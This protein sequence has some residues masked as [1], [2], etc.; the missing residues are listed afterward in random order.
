MNKKWSIIIG[1]IILIS[2]FITGVFADSPIKL[3]VNGQEI[4]PDAAPQIINGNTMVPISWVAK[5][6]GADVKWDKQNNAVNITRPYFVSNQAEAE[7]KLYPFQNINGM[8][9]GFILEVKGERKYFA[10]ENVTNPTYAPELLFADIN[11]DSEKEL[12]ILLTT[13]TGTGVHKEDIHVINPGMLT[14]IAVESPADIV[15]QNINTKMQSD[16]DNMVIQIITGGKETTIIKEKEYSCSWFNNVAF[17]S[18]CHYEVIN[19]KLIVR[20]PAQV[21]PGSF[22]GE[23]QATYIFENGKYRANTINFTKTDY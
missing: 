16:G 19:N 20:I 6:L 10:W 18:I 15:K 23:I 5:A 9:R 22:V 21:S 17:G 13:G 3:I 12:I 7:A 14:E 1:S 4:K 8:Y 2:I 11:Q